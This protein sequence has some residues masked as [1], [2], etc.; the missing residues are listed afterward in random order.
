MRPFG[1]AKSISGHQ[2][3]QL[4]RRPLGVKGS[5]YVVTLPAFKRCLEDGPDAA[6]RRPGSGLPTGRG[7]GDGHLEAHHDLQ[8]RPARPEKATRW[9]VRGFIVP[10][11]PRTSYSSSFK[12]GGRDLFSATEKT[13]LI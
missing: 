11:A 1:E 13:E 8:A 3:L 10:A 4:M 5:V 2:T 6:E 7:T 12:A 9:G